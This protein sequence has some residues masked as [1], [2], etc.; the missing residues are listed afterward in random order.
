MSKAEEIAPGY[1]VRRPRISDAP[2]VYALI[3]ASDIEEFGESRGYE[4]DELL[5]DWKHVDREHDLWV[6][7]AP[8]G[9]LAGYL[10]LRDRGHVRFD[11]EAYIHPAHFG[12][13]LGTGM[14]HLAEARARQTMPLAPQAARVVL[15]NWINALNRD[16]VALL[17]REGYA[18]VRFFWRMEAELDGLPESAAWPAG[19]SV[20]S[21]EPGQDLRVFYDTSEEAMAD[22]WGHSKLSYDSWLEQKQGAGFDPTLWFLARER[23]T[24]AGVALCKI[25]DGLGW[26]NI[27]GVREPWRRRGLGLAL[28]R[29]AMRELF[30]RGENRIGLVVDSG[31]ATGAT[32]L[33]ERAGLHVAQNY[34]TFGK[35]LRPG[36][37][38]SVDEE[39]A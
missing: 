14:I 30:L 37:E 28:L 18:P 36:V 31:N 13:G 7:F 17:E 8:D 26:I 29:H 10:Y 22:H 19:I 1:A 33:Y 23:D 6:A 24:P 5:D 4:L 12:R 25:S 32:R 35:E 39:D 2:D 20:C 38:V 27:L 15:N 34:A 3:V 9:G 16:A 21:G 11:S